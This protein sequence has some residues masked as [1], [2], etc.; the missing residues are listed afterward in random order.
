MAFVS[1]WLEIAAANAAG[2]KKGTWREH[3]DWVSDNSELIRRTANDPFETVEHRK[4]FSDPFHFCERVPRV[5]RRPERSELRFCQC[6]STVR[7]MGF[8]IWRA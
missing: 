6:F 7:R 1:H 4:K 5:D 2:E 8:S 3:H